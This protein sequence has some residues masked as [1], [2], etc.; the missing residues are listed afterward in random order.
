MRRSPPRGLTLDDG[1]A[2]AE[3]AADHAA[4]AALTGRPGRPGRLARAV[5]GLDPGGARAPASVAR[6]LAEPGRALDP[7][8]RHQA[9]R[10]LGQELSTVRVHTGAAAQ[11]SLSDVDAHA[12]AVGPHLV[13]GAEA[14]D[15]TTV[16]GR[17]LLAH[18]LAH[19]VQGGPADVVRRYRRAGSMA[20]R[21]RDMSYSEPRINLGTWPPSIS[22]TPRTLTEEPFDVRRDKETKPW[23]E[24]VDVV[25]S[26]T[27]TDADGR[28]FAIGT[29]QARYYANPFAWND[30]TL[31]VSGGSG[32]MRTDPGSFTVHRIEGY[33]YNSGSA[34][35]TPGVDFDWSDREQR[36]RGTLDQRYTKK[37]PLTGAR[38]ANMSF[39][40]F[41]N[42]GEALHAG[43]LD[44][45]SHGCVHVDWATV[46]TGW[47][48]MQ[49]LNY[50][51]VIGLT[52]V[53]VRY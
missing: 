2:A 28:V 19:V 47:S 24:Q 35:G 40:V 14:Q 16:R 12:Y 4:R 52:K 21:E 13:L 9:E 18:E 15:H 48:A 23:I 29:A 45:T 53:T 50:H 7:G 20:F 44:L 34:S 51:S 41:Y 36:R 32:R 3:R 5:A 43:P 46:D 22:L 26:G 49:Q 42:G 10:Q 31:Q 17:Y 37:D 25:F 8:V 27:Q 39:A 38:P 6:V 33:G 30:F 1:A 11:R